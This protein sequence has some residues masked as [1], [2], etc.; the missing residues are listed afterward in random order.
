MLGNTKQTFDKIFYTNKEQT[1]F[2][3]EETVEGN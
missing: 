2:I 3:K 1:E